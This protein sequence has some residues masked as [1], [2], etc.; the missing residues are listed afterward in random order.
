VLGAIRV[1]TV[2]DYNAVVGVCSKDGVAY[3]SAAWGLIREMRSRGL[4]PNLIT[5]NSLIKVG[6]AA[7]SPTQARRALQV[8][9]EV[10]KPVC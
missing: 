5:Y 3:R 2:Q 7:K 8:M 4:E 1:P 10:T 9:H 6:A